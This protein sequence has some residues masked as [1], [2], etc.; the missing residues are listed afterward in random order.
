MSL[1]RRSRAVCDG[2]LVLLFIAPSSVCAD[3]G[4]TE[5]DLDSLR[6]ASVATLQTAL[7]EEKE[8]VKVHAAEALL[9]NNYRAGVREEFLNELKGEAFDTYKVGIWRV[10]VQAAGND[11]A[12]RKKYLDCIVAAAKDPKAPNRAHALEALGKLG[13]CES[14]PEITEVARNGQGALQALAR[15]V[16]ANSGTRESETE[17][18]SLLSSGQEA[19]RAT[20]AY[21][22]RYMHQINPDT[23]SRLSD[24]C[25]KEK[26]SSARIYLLSALYVHSGGEEHRSL[27]DKTRGDLL[28]YVASGSKDE[29]NELACA[30][31]KS[32]G[33]DDL[34][35]LRTL[36]NDS[37]VDVRVYASNALLRIIQRKVPDPQQHAWSLIA[38]CGVLV[39]G[40]G[41]WYARRRKHPQE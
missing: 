20:V 14:T 5:A 7:K 31:A 35:T 25:A 11:D 30:L 24:A 2:V 38:L 8:W 13:W 32:G 28:A 29:K 36:R 18:A 39:L 3:G 40:I 1:S 19:V 26:K 12:F 17:L 22:L 21:A 10:L 23:Y 37:E 27:R 4:S 33:M 15:W 16:V 6:K 34:S 9:S 41:L